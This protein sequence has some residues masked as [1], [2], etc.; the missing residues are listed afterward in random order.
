MHIMLNNIDASLHY[1]GS[2]SIWIINVMLNI[3]DVSIKNVSYIN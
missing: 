1:V 3:I 2:I